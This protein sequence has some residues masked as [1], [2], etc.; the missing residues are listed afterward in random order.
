M[1]LVK[2]S[3]FCPA[4]KARLS[5]MSCLQMICFFLKRSFYYLKLTTAPEPKQNMLIVNYRMTSWQVRKAVTETWTLGHILCTVLG[6]CRW[7][8]HVLP[9]Y[10]LLNVDFPY[11]FTLSSQ[12]HIKS[13]RCIIAT[14]WCC[15]DILTT[16]HLIHL[17]PKIHISL[18]MASFKVWLILCLCATSY[19]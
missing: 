7:F 18:G 4:P 5:I 2:S 13:L 14:K 6:T 3:S 16:L 1:G 15:H 11:S 19:Y 17:H 8:K 12:R 10:D 9:R